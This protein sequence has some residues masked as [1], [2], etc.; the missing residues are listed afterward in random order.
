M[1]DALMSDPSN[2]RSAPRQAA[3]I[4]VQLDAE[5][6]KERFGV[7]H[8]ISTRGT[9]IYTNSKFEVGERLQISLYFTREAPKTVQ[10][11]VVRIVRQ[12]HA[13]LWRY[14]LGLRFDPP[15]AELPRAG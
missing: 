6:R 9:L 2:R 10:S 11:H 1:S 3:V 15:L 12:D 14:A 8:D 13:P 5:E 4:P 7:T